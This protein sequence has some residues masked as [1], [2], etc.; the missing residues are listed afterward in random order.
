MPRPARAGERGSAVVD[1]VLVLLVLLP[2]VIGILQLALVLHVRNT[3]ASA[4][5]EGAR[6]AAVAG[7][8]GP[9][10]RAKIDELVD[11][12]LSQ[13]FVRSVTVRPAL[14]GGAPGYE[15]VVEADIGLLGLKALGG[16]QVRVAGHAVAE[17]DAGS[18]P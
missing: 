10:G 6:H 16:V 18:V 15:A 2:L 5:A 14:V 4:A 1:F 11:G 12:A 7:S 8:S 9:A 3:L 13:D 17:Q